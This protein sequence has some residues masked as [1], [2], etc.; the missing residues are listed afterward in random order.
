MRYNITQFQ[1]I[2]MTGTVNG[3]TVKCKNDEI[4][5]PGSYVMLNSGIWVVKSKIGK[6]III[7]KNKSSSS[8]IN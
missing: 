7:R 6:L 5:Y 4:I 3:N 1:L 8:E 2:A